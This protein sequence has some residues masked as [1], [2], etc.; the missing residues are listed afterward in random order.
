MT[1]EQ[2]LQVLSWHVG[3]AYGITARELA[4]RCGI[5]EREVR[6]HVSELRDEGIAVC[7]HP[8]TGYFI[9]QTP[10]ELDMACNYLR[11]RALHSLMLESRMRKISMAELLGQIKVP[12]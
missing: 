12:T 3:Q 2:F 11:R 6:R 4:E 7:A 9:A 5:A 1:T 10:A 8:R